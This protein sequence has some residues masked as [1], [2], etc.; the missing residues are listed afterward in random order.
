MI[1]KPVKSY[2]SDIIS[3]VNTSDRPIYLDY[4]AATPVAD[5]VVD[6]MMPYLSDIFYNPSSSYFAAVTVRR[7][8]EAA[9]STL[10]QSFGAKGDEL[11]MTAGATESVNLAFHQSRGHVVTTAIEHPAVLEA[12]KKR[13]HTL[14][15]VNEKGR[16]SVDDVISAIQPNTDFIS[17]GLANSELGT[18]QPIRKLAQEIDLV[19]K[20]RAEQGNT[21][22]LLFHSDASQGFGLIDIHVARLGVDLLTLNAAKIYGPKQVGLLWIKPSV[23]MTADIVGG[24]QERGL[25]SGTENIAG[26]IGFSVAAKRAAATQKSESIRIAALRD[27]LQKRLSDTFDTA[28]TLGDAKHRL[29]GHLSMAF[30]GIDAERIIFMVEDE[31]LVATGSACSANKQTASH[32]LTAIGLDYKHL[33]GSLRMTLGSGSDEAS[34]TRAADILI[35][36]LK[37]EYARLKEA[38]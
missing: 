7:E 8:Y 23:E 4:A 17:I 15:S 24:G 2:L 27:M 6:A 29:P 26:V 31:V 22:P 25:R 1:H 37:K 5:F 12:A 32:V 13:K 10:A 33:G 18:I 35:A 36:A 16:V 3:I 11:V 14:V 21:T 28:M 38:A 20:E 9:K 30:P 34:I 19:R